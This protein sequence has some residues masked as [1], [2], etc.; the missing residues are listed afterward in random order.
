MRCHDYR[1]GFPPD[2]GSLRASLFPCCTPDSC[3][4]LWR[5]EG[6]CP[7]VH[8][9]GA[10]GDTIS[11]TAATSLLGL[12]ARISAP[13]RHRRRL[14]SC[15]SRSLLL[16]LVAPDSDDGCSPLS[17]ADVSGGLCHLR[18]SSRVPAGC[19]HACAVGPC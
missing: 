14:C 4:V 8:E 1:Q 11:A 2:Q 18:S 7:H 15:S 10:F 5:E 16:L 13:G 3:T 6:R 17:A 9:D 19:G 12:C